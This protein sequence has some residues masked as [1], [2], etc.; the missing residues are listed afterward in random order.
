MDTIEPPKK[1]VVRRKKRKP[2]ASKAP[3][4][5]KTALTRVAL[6]EMTGVTDI[7]IK[8]LTKSQME[9]I[10]KEGGIGPWDKVNPA[11]D[12]AIHM[13]AQMG[14]IEQDTPPTPPRTCIPVIP[15]FSAMWKPCADAFASNV[16]CVIVINIA[17]QKKELGFW[18]S[19]VKTL[20]ANQEAERVSR[21]RKGKP[22]VQVTIVGYLSPHL[23][24]LEIKAQVRRYEQELGIH[25]FWLD[26]S[27]ETKQFDPQWLACD[28]Y[29]DE[30]TPL[31]S[32]IAQ[33]GVLRVGYATS[34]TWR[35][36][37]DRARQTACYA[38]ML[39]DCSML[40]PPHWWREWLKSQ[41]T[42]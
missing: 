15:Y 37:W 4:V 33:E 30:H 13:A 39:E 10:A 22:P 40:M 8:P 42:K 31:P 21:E 28:H 25:Q 7:E 9:A 3:R 38:A 18:R 35:Q 36:E 17:P 16:D 24:A 27:E 5:E 41:L 32:G 29:G 20:R 34:K 26:R 23:N 1:K 6:A 11:D 12:P 19:A 2:Y 14:A